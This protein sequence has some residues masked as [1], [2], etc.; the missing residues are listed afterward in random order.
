MPQFAWISCLAVWVLWITSNSVLFAA[1]AEHKVRDQLTRLHAWLGEDQNAAAWKNHLRSAELEQE[2]TSGRQASLEKVAHLFAIYSQLPSHLKSGRFV[3]VEQAL[4]DWLEELSQARPDQLAV[5]ARAAK[6][7]FQPIT[8]EDVE[9]AK[10]ELVR[11][12]RALDRF[13]ASGNANN[14]A[15][16]QTFLRWKELQDQVSSAAPEAE[17]L[18][19][20][21]ERFSRNEPGLEL[22]NFRKVRD[23]IR[24]YREIVS[25]STGM[26]REKYAEQLDKLADLLERFQQTNS[27]DISGEIGPILG[28][29]ESSQQAPY[30][31]AAVRQ[32][33]WRP[34][35]FAE[36][37]SDF[38]AAGIDDEV[39]ETVEVNDFYKG[40]DLH[41]T[42]TTI[43]RLGLVLV[44][45]SDRASFEIRLSGTAVS[46]NVGYH[47]PVTIYSSGVTQINAR[48][49]LVADELGLRL[50]PATA[51]CQTDSNIEGVAAKSCLVQRIASRQAQSSQPGAEAWASRKAERQVAQRMDRQSSEMLAE[52]NHKFL[53]KFRNPLI[54]RGEFPRTFKLNTTSDRL[55]LT[56]MQA[57]ARQLG[58]PNAPPQ[59]DGTHDLTLRIHESLVGNFS[60]A[61]IGG[62]TLTDERLEKLVLDLTGEIPDELKI[63]PDKDPWSITFAADRPIDTQ[64]KDDMLTISVRGRR[65]TRQDQNLRY[66]VDITAI[67]KVEKSPEVTKLVRQGDVEVVF[68][69]DKNLG[70]GQVTFKTFIRRK[71]AALFRPEIVGEGLRLKGRWEHIGRL[72][73]ADFKSQGG[74]VAAGWQRPL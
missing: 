9:Q 33:Y 8:D 23:A 5:V 45:D 74:W 19:Q 52:P 16:W 13:L 27:A 47:G 54:R 41:G 1:D 55:F 30:L 65:F 57:N 37:S 73:L 53:E 21:E 50:N 67:Y 34:N 32:H 31:V 43:G 72:N 15:V 66:A 44:P 14:R 56:G 70:V 42:A 71:F 40:T 11:A 62:E 12:I 29:L 69:N 39:N 24:R 64:F 48:K 38:L 7:R 17:V 22:A 4:Q 46:K 3:A 28:W 58:A 26:Q 20:N 61:L 35:V 51:R 63:G 6:L 59:A 68:V 2:L 10:S 60:E 49:P 36:V 18:R 25:A